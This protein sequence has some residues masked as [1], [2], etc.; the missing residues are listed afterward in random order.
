MVLFQK[1]FQVLLYIASG[2][3]G[4][5]A[6]PRMISCERTEQESKYNIR[7][8]ESRVMA[9]QKVDRANFKTKFPKNE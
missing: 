1:S 8:I 7:L 6:N 2:G 3:P 9:D 4:L 5:L